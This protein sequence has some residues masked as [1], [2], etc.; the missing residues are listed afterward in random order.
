MTIMKMAMTALAVVFLAQAA[1]ALA[2]PDINNADAAERLEP[3]ER[4]G[5]RRDGGQRDWQSERP[6]RQA[7]QAA[8]PAPAPQ[9][10]QAR[11]ADPPRGGV[12]GDSIGRPGPWIRDGRRTEPREDQP[13][14][15]RRWDGARQPPAPGVDPRQ[16]GGQGGQDHAR[17]G[18]GHGR[19]DGA[20]GGGRGWDHQDRDG[21]DGDR[22]DGDRR[23]WDRRD[24]D[25]HG[26]DRNGRDDH[27]Y[28]H[29]RWDH[30][31]YPPVY[32]SAQ[33]YRH[34]WRPPVG[35]YS[36]SWGFGDYL[37]RSWYGGDYGIIDPWQYNLPLPPPG[38]DW[39][40]VGDDAVLID[41]FNGRVV[42]VVR[43]VFW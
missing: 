21:H 26:W 17:D 40:R 30:D 20:Q 28:D 19:P 23:D 39:V 42:Q 15:A 31:R 32:R 38:Y 6:Q 2:E 12:S 36:R 27:R 13:R 41:R 16:A 14:E 11:E 25:Q 5:G 8:T 1:P 34:A 4:D 29:R 9:A 3:R 33:R 18:G 35:F 24:R 7:P 22:H 43:F 37:P 10:P